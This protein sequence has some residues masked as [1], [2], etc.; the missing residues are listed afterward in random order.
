MR[1]LKSEHC[2]NCDKVWFPEK[3]EDG[4]VALMTETCAYCELSLCGRCFPR[5]EC[6]GHEI[7]VVDCTYCDAEITPKDVVKIDGDPFCQKCANEKPWDKEE[8]RP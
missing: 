2:D 4:D 6:S 7:E 8:V 5:H 3:D 1:R